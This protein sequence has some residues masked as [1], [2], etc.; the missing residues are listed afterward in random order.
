M[1]SPVTAA[2]L[3]SNP[4]HSIRSILPAQGS[5]QR[6]ESPKADHKGIASIVRVELSVMYFPLASAGWDR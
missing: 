3:Y 6:E 2:T 5:D 1:S 4:P